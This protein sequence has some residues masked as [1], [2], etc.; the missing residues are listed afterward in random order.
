MR[1]RI[2]LPISAYDRRQQENTLPSDKTICKQMPG[3]PGSYILEEKCSGQRIPGISRHHPIN[4]LLETGCYM[5]GRLRQIQPQYSLVGQ[6]GS[7]SSLVDTQKAC[8]INKYHFCGKNELEML[9]HKCGFQV[10]R[11]DVEPMKYNFASV[12]RFVQYASSS[13]DYIAEPG[14]L[15]RFGAVQPYIDW[16]RVLAVFRK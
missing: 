12:D 8:P 10:E 16:V 15:E 11:I 5:K 2:L 7:C 14:C 13:I 4:P 9:A 3:Q 6:I 1:V